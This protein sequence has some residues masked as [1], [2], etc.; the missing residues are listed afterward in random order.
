[1][2]SYNAEVKERWGSTTAYREHA[3]RAKDYTADKWQQA[4]DALNAVFAKFARCKKS[5]L[6]AESPETQELVK[7]LKACITENYYTCTNE[8]LTGL[9]E[10]YTADDRFT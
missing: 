5:G 6:A 4:Y 2:K 1:M 3:E 10:M 9:G 7:E 8:I